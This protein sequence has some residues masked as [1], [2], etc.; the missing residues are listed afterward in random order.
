MDAAAK[1]FFD[2]EKAFDQKIP[3]LAIFFDFAKAFDLVPHDA[4]LRKLS[5]IIP[6]CIVRWIAF[7]LSD[8]TQRVRVGNIT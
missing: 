2:L 4:L 7:Y 8:R 6:P 5:N 3:A 1:V